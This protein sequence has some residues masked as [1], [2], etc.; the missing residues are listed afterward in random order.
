MAIFRTFPKKSPSSSSSSSSSSSP[1]VSPPTHQRAT[2]TDGVPQSTLSAIHR[3]DHIQDSALLKRGSSVPPSA[4]SSE[5]SDLELARRKV[6]ILS[7]FPRA[8]SPTLPLSP[9]PSRSPSPSLE[10]PSALSLSNSSYP[11]GSSSASK[12]SRTR[13]AIPSPPSE[14]ENSEEAAKKGER[15]KRKRLARQ[16]EA[17][18]RADRLS[19]LR[20]RLEEVKRW[21]SDRYKELA[22]TYRGLA[23]SLKHKADARSRLYPPTSLPTFTSIQTLIELTDSILLWVYAFWADDQVTPGRVN[24]EVWKSLDGMK[25]V[26]RGGWEGVVKGASVGSSKGKRAR[27]EAAKGML[28]LVYLIDALVLLHITTYEQTI[29]HSRTQRLY[30]SST[31][32]RSTPM[33]HPSS[34]KLSTS[35]Y[36]HI[37]ADS[38]SSLTSS[39][40]SPSPAA[41]MGGAGGAASNSG[42]GGDL[43]LPLDYLPQVLGLTAGLSRG[44]RL[45]ATYQVNLTFGVIEK[46]FPR[47]WEIARRSTGGGNRRRWAKRIKTDL[48]VNESMD[49]LTSS[50]SSSSF[51]SSFVTNSSDEGDDT[52]DEAEEDGSTELLGA[53]SSLSE[54]ITD[55]AQPELGWGWPIGIFSPPPG[56]PGLPKG[57][58]V[59]GPGGMLPHLVVFGRSLIREWVARSM[60]QLEG[61]KSGNEKE[62]ARYDLNVGWVG[63]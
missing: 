13:Q 50:S 31:S 51:S 58:D 5:L 6:K 20:K 49:D 39:T 59:P 18:E 12:G 2:S 53:G 44:M 15:R 17:D 35:T 10:D 54:R 4:M 45:Y 57:V 60:N 7:S 19:R 11:S 26:V 52:E 22:H 16:K 55:P 46:R 34:S 3:I 25:K 47:T 30:S 63:V 48:P 40:S 23:R 32:A 21:D 38:P 61:V 33:P 28:G 27:E 42:N 41:F 56:T 36:S 62:S 29:L 43:G 24:L 37:S 9:P 14:I 1:Q 8:L